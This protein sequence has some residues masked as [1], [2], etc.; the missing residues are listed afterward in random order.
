MVDLLPPLFLYTS[1][2]IVV[3]KRS[4]VGK[5]GPRFYATSFAEG[6]KK[7]ARHLLSGTLT[8]RLYGV[9]EPIKPV[10]SKRA[11]KQ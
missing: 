11:Q 4:E 5:S 2:G 9:H 1:S 8:F 7:R 6:A 10:R 3:L